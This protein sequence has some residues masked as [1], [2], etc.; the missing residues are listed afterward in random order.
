MEQTSILEEKERGKRE[1]QRERGFYF[2]LR[3][4]PR[5][6]FQGRLRVWKLRT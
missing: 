2:R 6:V 5:A 3:A 1:R 4:I